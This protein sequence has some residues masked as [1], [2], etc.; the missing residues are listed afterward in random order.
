MGVKALAPAV[1]G[2]DLSLVFGLWEGAA[3]M[4]FLGGLILTCSDKFHPS[5]LFS[6][7]ATCF[8]STSIP[9]FVI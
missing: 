1:D 5:D 3:A 2:N 4:A 9:I 8:L 7:G 6:S